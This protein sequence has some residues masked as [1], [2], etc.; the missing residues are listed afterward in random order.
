MYNLLPKS[1][2]YKYSYFTSKRLN[3]KTKQQIQKMAIR[4][5]FLSLIDYL[6]GKNVCINS[7]DKHGMTALHY[8]AIQNNY[9]GAEKLLSFWETNIDV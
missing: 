2:L 7:I 9:I 1:K 6:R 8:A 4:N 5:S 3:F